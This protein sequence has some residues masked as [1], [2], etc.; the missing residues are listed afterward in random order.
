MSNNVFSYDGETGFEGIW[1]GITASRGFAP[2]LLDPPK[3]ATHWVRYTGG[4]TAALQ[5][6]EI[7]TGGTS[8]ATCRLVAIA[9]ENGTAGSS[10]SGIILINNISGTLVA[11][12]LTGTLST[13]T[14]AI[15]QAPILLGVYGPPKAALFTVEG[16]AIHVSLSGTTPTV[17]AGTNFGVSVGVGGSITVRGIG[18]I[19]KVRL[20]NEVNASGSIVKYVLLW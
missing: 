18:N 12:T 11:E 3:E 6:G 16:F 9:V 4:A 17:A 7:L 13:G 8:S 5:V 19:R 20:I 1:T 2:C 15:A 10:D 14:V